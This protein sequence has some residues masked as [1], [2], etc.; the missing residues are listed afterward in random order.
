M[1]KVIAGAIVLAALGTKANAQLTNT[2]TASASAKIVA[3]IT[4]EK[5]VDL[6]FGSIVPGSGGTVTIAATSG[7]ARTTSLAVT[8]AATS[9]AKF[10]VVGEANSSY[11]ISVT[12]PTVTLSNGTP[13]DDMT[14]SLLVSADGTNSE[15]TEG[16]LTSGSQDIYVGGTL[17]VANAQAAGQYTAAD[18][19]EIMVAYN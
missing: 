11:A 14:V 16:T 17:T 19:I 10:T 5:K 7:G 8:N 3:A 18:A 6:N 4:I 12:N 13:A 1:N 2:A 9:S 15:T